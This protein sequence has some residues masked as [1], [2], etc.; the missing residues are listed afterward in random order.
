MIK[1]SF[2]ESDKLQFVAGSELS[3]LREPA[4]NFSLS[5]TTALLRIGA[6]LIQASPQGASDN[7]P[8]F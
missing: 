6:R 3:R 1:V 2:E 7:R 5:Y 8:R 4:T